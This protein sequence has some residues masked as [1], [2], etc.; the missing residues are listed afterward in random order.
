MWG[1][2]YTPQPH[3][4]KWPPSTLTRFQNHNVEFENVLY[5]KAEVIEEFAGRQEKLVWLF[6]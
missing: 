2:L 1:T 5:R 4:N 3:Q 6:W